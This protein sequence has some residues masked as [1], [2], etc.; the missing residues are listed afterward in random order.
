MG[1]A[2]SRFSETDWTKADGGFS[3]KAACIDGARPTPAHMIISLSKHSIVNQREFDVRDDQDILLYDTKAVDG[4]VTWFDVLGPGGQKLL[5]VE[6][7][8]QRRHWD[9]FAFANPAFPGQQPDPDATAQAGEPLYKKARLDITWDSYHAT[10]SLYGK[11]EQPEGAVD[12][13]GT[14]VGD[15]ILKVEEIKSITAQF[16][17]HLPNKSDSLVGFWVWE[18]TAKTHRIKMHLAKNSD[19]A[20]HIALA[21]MTN[22][23]HNQRMARPVA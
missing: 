23:V 3:P 17:T 14:V 5:R 4:T 12:T 16:Q 9:V 22:M 18:H 13:T 19:T 11:D 21:V 10:L 20:L 8:V 7:D 1:G 15:P 2:T 6:A